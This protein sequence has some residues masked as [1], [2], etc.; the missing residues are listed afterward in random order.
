[1]PEAIVLSRSKTAQGFWLDPAN[2]TKLAT[3]LR[4]QVS[5]SQSF[6]VEGVDFFV[7]HM[8]T[9]F[10]EDVQ[11]D[12]ADVLVMFIYSVRPQGLVRM[13]TGT[14]VFTKEDTTRMLAVLKKEFP[15]LIWGPWDM[16]QWWAGYSQG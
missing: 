12:E 14:Y 16:P 2:R 15:N 7:D 6:A 13:E 3:A 10:P 4:G 5:T 9:R 11:P 8:Y 1:M